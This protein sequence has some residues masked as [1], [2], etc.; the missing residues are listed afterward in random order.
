MWRRRDW[1]IDAFNRNM[2]YD[3]FTVE[4]LAGDLLPNPTLS[5]KSAT[6]FNRNHRTNREGGIIPE[7]YRSNTSPIARKPLPPL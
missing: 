1:I 4:Q 5:Q 2:P 3:Q 6:G 7:E